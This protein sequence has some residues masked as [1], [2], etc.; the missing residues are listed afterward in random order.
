MHHHL[1]GFFSNN[2]MLYNISTSSSASVVSKNYL[3]PFCLEW[4]VGLLVRNGYTCCSP[5]FFASVVGKAAQN[6]IA[7]KI[8]AT[9]DN[10]CSDRN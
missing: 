10:T 7:R 5:S 1:T 6:R 8:L 4:D 3:S 9:K 2:L